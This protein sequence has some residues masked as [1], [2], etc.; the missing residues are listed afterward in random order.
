MS[1]LPSH[2]T[3]A[4]SAVFVWYLTLPMLLL[5][6]IKNK[7]LGGYLSRKSWVKITWDGFK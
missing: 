5:C 1:Y 6:P 3:G 7:T 2:P 4:D